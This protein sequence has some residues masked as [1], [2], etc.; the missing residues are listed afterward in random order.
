MSIKQVAPGIYFSEHSVAKFSAAQNKEQIKPTNITLEKKSVDSEKKGDVEI[1]SW[2]ANNDAPQKV[3]DVI[4]KIGVAGKVVQ[5][6]TAA[7]FGTGLTLFE[8]DE[9]GN[10]NRVPYKKFPKIREFDKINNFNL[11]YSESINDL[12][13][14]DMCF[15][16]FCLTK[17]YNSIY[18]IKRQQPSHSRFVIMNEKTGRIEYVALC[19]DWEN[20]NEDNVFIIPCFSQYDYWEDIQEACKLKK[21]QN[22]VIAFHYVKNGEVYYNQPFWHA[23]LK[24]GWAD[25][26]L[27]VP[28]VKNAIAENQL[29][30][31]YVIHV[32]EEYFQRAY[33]PNAAGGWNWN[34]FTA[35]K[36]EK[37]K[38]ALIDA[39][40]DHLRGKKAAGR[41]LSVPMFTTAD[42][43]FVKSIEVEVIEDKIKDGAYLPDA[44][45][46]NYEIAF[47]KGVDPAII[48]AGIPG[49]KTQSGS[50]SDKRE[51]YTILCANMVINRTVSLL[52]FYLIRD[53]NK[54]GDDLDAGFPNIVLT[55][56]DKEP[57]GKT[58]TTPQ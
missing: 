14:H 4:K 26:I 11:F 35:E 58:E 25:V 44:S 41:S 7:H 8:E 47:A 19:A 52:I 13:I 2:G 17:D 49:G 28:E 48:G 53:W 36:Q 54:W 51:A 20:A 57:S 10:R 34:D 15:T 30:F 6:A 33:G 22:F 16:E 21:I 40:D 56:L 55:T 29:H 24:N 38:S 42:G 23:P 45:A 5:V 46:G 9:K 32:S 50:G 27:S 1:V 12:E 39:I 3:L 31:K 37:E 43:K 18:Y